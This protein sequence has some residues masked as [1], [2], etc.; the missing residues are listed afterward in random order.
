[1]QSDMIILTRCF[2]L[3]AWLLPK[4]EKF[5]RIYRH[6]LTQ[7]IMLTALELQENLITAQA[8]RQRDRVK[9]LRLCDAK[10]MQL[11][12]Y[13]RLIHQWQWLSDKQY[14]YISAIIAEIGKMLGAWLKKE[15]HSLPHRQ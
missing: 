9:Y 14:H 10:L 2:D 12:V 1:M 13:L 11:R 8:Y 3:L 4:I 7:R 5:P 15:I 6:T